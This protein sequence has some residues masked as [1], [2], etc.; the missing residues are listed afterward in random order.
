MGNRAV[1]TTR[2][3]IIVGMG[4]LTYLIRVLPQLFF[5][6]RAFSGPFDRYLHYLAYAL[7][8]NGHVLSS[9]GHYLAETRLE[10]CGEVV[11]FSI[12]G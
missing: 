8:V 9:M 6:G 5:V 11:G 2:I 12:I 10:R 3:A 7:I 1:Y 4:L